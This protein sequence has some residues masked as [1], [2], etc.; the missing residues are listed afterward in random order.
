M[1]RSFLGLRNHYRKMVRMIMRSVIN[2]LRGLTAAAV[3][4]VTGG[5]IYYSEVLPDSYY[6]TAG[7]TLSIEECIQVR[8]DS[9]QTGAVVSEPLPTVRT[10]QLRLFGIFPVKEVTVTEV[11]E[12]VVVP[13]GTPF[14]I[15]II[16]EGVM[17]VDL[18]G[19][20]T[21]MG[22]ISP[23][24]EAGIEEGDIISS[25]G[26]K[27]VMSNNDVST[28]IEKEG[29]KV[30]GVELI[31]DGE[32]RVVFLK[33]R[34]SLTDGVYRAGMW[35]RDSSAGIGTVTF[36]IP[37]NH[38][39]AGLGHPVCD[40]DTGEIL[41]MAK[42]EAASVVISGVRKSSDGDPG[43]LIGMFSSDKNC[44]PLIR[45]SESGVYGIFES[46]PVNSQPIP[47]A[48]RQEVRTGSAVILATISGTKAEE[49]EIEIEKVDM[50]GSSGHD[51]VVHI[52]DSRLLDEAG[53]I[54]QGMS[55]SPIIQNGRLVGAVTH[56]LVRDP[57]RGYGIFADTMFTDALADDTDSASAS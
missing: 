15:K 3:I 25:I 17:V 54:V 5:I 55:G 46:C 45:N 2:I 36:Y 49:Y 56:V 18:T 24:R 22:I 26:G 27:K 23:A 40:T 11:D 33:P 51:L 21:D 32:R 38:V 57:T 44:G 16:T 37:G 8:A 9:L 48:M 39:F 34:R 28:I 1:K 30:L 12:P 14:G 7:S 10:E 6:V 13:C 31:R 53:G 47:V 43:E 35:V 42:G 41:T 4:A 20:D 50:G 52:T 29:G 19:F